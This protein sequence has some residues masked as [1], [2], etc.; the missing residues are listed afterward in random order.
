MVLIRGLGTRGLGTAAG[1]GRLYFQ[2]DR[3]SFLGKAHENC[4]NMRESEVQLCVMVITSASASASTSTP[5]S[6]SLYKLE[7]LVN[8][9][10]M[11]N[12]M[13][14]ANLLI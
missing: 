11:V 4:T 10:I 14:F 3:S 2:R 5:A 8:L 1:N 6:A 9:A 7:N 12:L 13:T